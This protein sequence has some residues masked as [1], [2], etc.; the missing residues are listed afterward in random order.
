MSPSERPL[1]RTVIKE[2]F[3]ALTGDT[4]SAIIL[5]QLEYWQERVRSYDRFLEEEQRRAAQEGLDLSQEPA[6]G[7]IYKS[8]E[9]LAKES[10]ISVSAV[11]IRRR[12]KELVDAGYVLERRNPRFKWD[13]TLQY[14]LDLVAIDRALREIGYSL[15]GWKLP[16]AHVGARHNLQNEGSIPQNEESNLHSDIAI[17]ESTSETT[18]DGSPKDE[19]SSSPAK[20]MTTKTVQRTREV[21]FEAN[22]RQIAGW[23]SGWKAYLFPKSGEPPDADEPMRVLLKIVDAAAGN[24]SRT[25]GFYISVSKAVE[26]VRERD[27]GTGSRQRGPG[28][29]RRINTTQKER[30]TL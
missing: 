8:A 10:Q 25:G 2:E 6:D 29:N 4:N 12:L 30:P 27:S 11:T 13:R 26:M 1:L 28:K 9:E 7:W 18:T 5:A 15:Q 23:G 22:R 20:E 21:G 14:R 3:L 17:P 16:R 19:I 24:L